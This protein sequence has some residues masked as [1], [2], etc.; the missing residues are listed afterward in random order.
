MSFSAARTAA[1]LLAVSGLAAAGAPGDDRTTFFGGRLRLG[2]EVSGSLAPEDKGFFNYTD[3]E[4]NTLR[5]FRIEVLA[6]AQLHSKAALLFDARMDN[7]QTP[8]V[9]ALY[10][11]LRPWS[12]RDFDVQLGLVPPVFG[13]FPRRRY[14]F[15][16]PL[17]SLPLVYQYL[18]T[19]REDALPRNA[20]EVVAQRGRGWLVRYPIGDTSF[21]PGRPLVNAE[22]W[23][24]GIQARIGLRPV[25]LALAVTQGTLSHPTVEDDNGG[26]QISGRLA[27]MPGP[28]F[29]AGLSASSGDFVADE[30]RDEL[31]G[32]GPGKY[33]Q[34]ALGLDLE[35]ARGH[36]IL[37]GEAVFSSWHLPAVDATRIEEPLDALGAFVEA[38]YK[39]RPGFYVA[40][41]VERL[42]MAEIGSNLGYLSWDAD[43]TRFELGVGYSPL[44]QRAAEGRLAA[45]PARRRPRAKERSRRGAGA[46]VVLTRAGGALALALVAS[47]AAAQE[48]P[49]EPLMAGAASIRGRVEV[50]RSPHAEPARPQVAE[51]GMPASREAGDRRRSVVY[52]ETVPQ[53]AFE[54]PSPLRAVLD[55][56]NETFVP[57]VV[58]I[59]VGSS[60]DFPNSD[61][62]YHNVFSLSKTRRFDL[63]RYPRGQS[64]SV[65]F[66]RT[67]SSACSARSTRT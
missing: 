21:G 37:R 44:R 57:P 63:G 59:T 55:Q 54:S 66:D 36:L 35:W 9:Y 28:S 60:V 20:E 25:S 14:A 58:A 48:Q 8:R 42:A 5:L 16:N 22:R 4:A 3:Y 34:Q 52:L 2:G 11:R 46:A 43:V 17:P 49:A 41:R 23:D 19:I 45:Q 24:A 13:S 27:W 7:L 62:V 53:S 12:S 40:S 50:R 29:T 38:R 39:L 15:D 51:L 65:V 18:T 10:L 30:A 67:G 32:G 61:K 6:E 26:K 47:G 1:L 31:P 64:R 33:R 56:R